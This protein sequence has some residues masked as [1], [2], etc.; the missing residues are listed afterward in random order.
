VNKEEEG[1]ISCVISS[2]YNYITESRLPHHAWDYTAPPDSPAA[3][4][5]SGQA[6][7]PQSRQEAAKNNQFSTLTA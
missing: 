7:E 6:Q 5:G 3:P 1:L 2:H 4:L